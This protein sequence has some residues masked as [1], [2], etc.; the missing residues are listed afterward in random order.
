M[1]LSKQEM[2]E[3]IQESI[4]KAL[5]PFLKEKNIE[6]TRVSITSILMDQLKFFSE[7]KSEYI[8]FEINSSFKDPTE[9]NI[10][11]KN[12]YTALLLDGIVEPYKLTENKKEFT[13]RNG[14]IYSYD[15]QGNVCKRSLPMIKGTFVLNKPL[16]N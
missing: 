15:D 6:Q 13:A 14:F 16:E 8:K 5:L 12:I 1:E 3:K 9:I 7:D 4:Q 10:I 11:P 2:T